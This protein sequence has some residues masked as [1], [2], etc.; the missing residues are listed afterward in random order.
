M[1]PTVVAA[2][3][4][5]TTTESSSWYRK[6]VEARLEALKDVVFM[7][8][9]SMHLDDPLTSAAHMNELITT[10]AELRVMY[11]E[12]AVSL[13]MDVEVYQARRGAAVAKTTVMMM[14]TATTMMHDGDDATTMRAA[15]EH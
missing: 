14:K 4:F 13:Q 5:P 9:S 10:L 7:N 11:E 8:V 12:R 2:I 15:V 1:N 3:A 6:R